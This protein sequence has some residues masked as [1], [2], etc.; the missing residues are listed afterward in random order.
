MNA[1]ITE[2]ELPGD[3]QGFD[4]LTSLRFSW[5]R[6]VPPVRQT[7]AAECGLACV[8]MVAGYYGHHIALSEFR[9]RRPVSTKGMTLVDLIQ[10]AETLGLAARPV[11]L[12]MEE[13]K[14]LTTPCILHWNLSHFVV[15][16]HVGKEWVRIIDPSSGARRLSTE[17]V[18]KFFTGVAIE[19]TTTSTFERASPPPSLSLRKLAGKVTGL[20]RS[21]A[22]VLG[23]ALLLEAFTLVAP[24]F[25]QLTVDQVLAD[26]DHDLLMFLGLTFSGLLLAQTTVSAVRTWA[27]M[28][29]GAQFT[30][31]WTGNVFRHLLK[32]PQ[33][34]FLSRH[35]GDISSRFSAIATIQQTLTTQLV[36][37]VLDGAMTL[38]TLCVL[39]A[40]SWLLACIT[41][42]AVTL[43][44]IS[45]LLYFRVYREA[46]LSQIMVEARRQSRFIES[47]KAAQTIRL[48]N[49]QSIST[50]RYLNATADVLNTQLTVQKLSL[51]FDAMNSLSSG[52]QRVAILWIGAWLALSGNLSAGMLVAFVSYA[53]QF[54]SRAS[55]LIDYLI[56]L[57]LLRL[58]GERLADIVTTKVEPFLHGSYAGEVDDTSVTLDRLSFRYGQGERWI[59]KDCSAHL[60]AGESVAIIGPSGC[61]KSTVLRLITGLL[62][63]QSGRILVGGVDMRKLG[64]AR[65]RAMC[66][67]V[68]QDD[69]AFSGSIA[70]NISMFDPGATLDKVEAAA[71]LAQLHDD[72]GAM[73]MGYN[74]LVGSMGSSLS[75]GQYQRL[76]LARA[77]Y[78]EPRFL[79]LD[80]SSSHL[81]LKT[82]ALINASIASL[83]ITRIIIAHRPETIRT[84]DRVLVLDSGSLRPHEPAPID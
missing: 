77:L 3:E 19:F 79:F 41:L 68:M 64:K 35:I 81:D 21:I 13:L 61:G 11:K 42:A 10:A 47:V 16:E 29:V 38:I 56:Q 34:Y 2:P 17:D 14:N 31:N 52:A 65:F 44:G 51:V 49:Q 22:T 82:E 33:G 73:P 25:L 74:S 6:R 48:A 57:R 55:S 67:V 4:A 83:K 53:D 1:R 46:N 28:W 45:R 9:Q 39:F 69:Q 58:Q 71:R 50:G 18:G 78:R 30:F 54:V 8:A 43:Y 26:Q 32:L 75:G 36:S 15:L 40:Y 72:I 76:L 84:A 23:L 60:E 5:L 62:D 80:E 20:R 12:D 7:E 63:A 27:L 37:G 24:Q 59:V 70:D 66:G